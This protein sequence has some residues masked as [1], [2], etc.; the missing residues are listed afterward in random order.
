MA[1]R[2][3][4]P[5][6]LIICLTFANGIGAFSWAAFGYVLFFRIVLNLFIIDLSRFRYKVKDFFSV[7]HLDIAPPHAG[8]LMGISNMMATFAGM[9]SANLA[10]VIVINHV[11]CFY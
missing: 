7:N 1:T 4:E 10:G 6:H 8:V 5:P 9:L 3:N 2:V 11:S